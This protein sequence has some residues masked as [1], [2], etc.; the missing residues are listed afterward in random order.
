MLARAR[1]AFRD[2]YSEIAA[3]YEEARLGG[4]SLAEKGPTG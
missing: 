3:A 2:G 4:S 1:Q